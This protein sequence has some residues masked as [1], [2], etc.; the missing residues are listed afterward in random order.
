V[1]QHSSEPRKKKVGK[2]KEKKK[3][4]KELENGR[5][6]EATRET[7]SKLPSSTTQNVKHAENR[8]KKKKKKKIATS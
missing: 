2:K 3:K 6:K 4:E 8:T 1:I 5:N 7:G